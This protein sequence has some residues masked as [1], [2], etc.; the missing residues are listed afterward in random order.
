MILN[1][2]TNTVLELYT[3]LPSKATFL[4]E[5]VV[6]AKEDDKFNNNKCVQCWDE[7]TDEHPGVKISP[8]GHV[9]GRDCLVDITNSPTGDL[10][11]YCRVK[12]FRQPPTV[13][14]FLFA[15]VFQNALISYEHLIQR[16][17]M[18]LLE[19][20]TA[21]S[22]R[23]P[24]HFLPVYWILYGLAPWAHW[25]VLRHTDICTRNPHLNVARLFTNTAVLDWLLAYGF[26]YVAPRLLPVYLTFGTTAFKITFLAANVV[27]VVFRQALV[28][29][30]ITP[31]GEL[32]EVFAENFDD[33]SDRDL[34]VYL[35]AVAIAAQQLCIV[36]LLW[37]AST[38]GFVWTVCS[39]AGWR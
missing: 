36:T 38:L 21:V 8:C 12:L 25:F 13:R 19:V 29:G 11:P 32:A 34:I 9:F 18:G 4:K 15:N 16:L 22:Y 26:P 3:G 1:N 23:Y 39:N 6:P 5:R 24:L 17:R 31:P 30:Y 27:S 20:V 28:T 7:Y 35:S 33:D 37:P 2:I 14:D 10:C